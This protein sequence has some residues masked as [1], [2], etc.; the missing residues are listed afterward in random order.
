MRKSAGQD[1]GEQ[2]EAGVAAEIGTP[3]QAVEPRAE[4]AGDARL[5][6]RARQ[7]DDAAFAA[8]V[9]RY[10]RKLLR[11]LGRLVQDEELARDLAQETFWKVYSRLDLFDTSRRFGPWLFQVG[12]NLGR[13]Q[14]RRSRPPV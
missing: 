1:A 3:G 13:D 10:E 4:E 2:A 12:V 6:E 7:G 9:G 14:L 8:L 5:V 11:V